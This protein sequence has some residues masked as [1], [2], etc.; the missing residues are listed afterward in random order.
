MANEAWGSGTL[1]YEPEEWQVWSREQETERTKEEGLEVR[2]GE[3]A[4]SL[5]AMGTCRLLTQ[6]SA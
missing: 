5:K 6:H 1:E 4:R 3:C 2:A